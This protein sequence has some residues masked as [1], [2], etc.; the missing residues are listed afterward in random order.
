MPG[1]NSLPH[2]SPPWIDPAAHTWFMTV[3]CLPK[4][5]NQLALPEVWR[6]IEESIVSRIERRLWWPEIFLCMP[7]HC[8]ALLSF[9]EEGSSIP[10]TMRDWKHWLAHRLGIAWQRDFFDHRLRSEESAEQ[11]MA[12]IWQNP[13]RANLTKRPEDWTYVWRPKGKYAPPG[14]AEG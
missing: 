9:P 4:G 13:V 11:K 12:Y 6:E 10:K 3:C 5:K 7:D 1:R 14:R 8:H 2:E